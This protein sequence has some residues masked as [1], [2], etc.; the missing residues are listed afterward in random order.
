MGLWFILFTCFF[1][2]GNGRNF[3]PYKVLEISRKATASEIK[4]AYR[5]LARRFHP[6]KASNAQRA[7]F[8]QRM[9]EINEA[10]EVLTD[11]AQKVKVD[12]SLSQFVR[13]THENFKYIARKEYIWII[14]IHSHWCRD[15]P[16]ANEVMQ[17]VCAHFE[18][19]I[20]C[21]SISSDSELRLAQELGVRKVPTIL[22]RA[23]GNTYDIPFMR[24]RTDPS[25]VIK[26]VSQRFPTALKELKKLKYVQSFLQ[27]S[28]ERPKAVFV[29]Q[30][31]SNPHIMHRW[32]AHQFRDH[33]TFCFL[34]LKN[35]HSSETDQ[36][37][38]IIGE[39]LDVPMLAL[40]EG[41]DLLPTVI[42]L[43]NDPEQMF[44][45]LDST[46][47]RVPRIPELQATEYYNRCYTNME[48]SLFDSSK[49]CILLLLSKRSLWAKYQ[50]KLVPIAEDQDAIQFIW[51]DCKKQNVFCNEWTQAEGSPSTRMFQR[52]VTLRIVGV[53]G[54]Q[55]IHS[56]SPI[57]TKHPDYL[58][59]ED[60]SNWVSKFVKNEPGIVM[61]HGHCTLPQLNPGLNLGSGFDLEDGWFQTLTSF[62]S[63]TVST[64]SSAIS[65]IINFLFTIFFLLVFLLVMCVMGGRGGGFQFRYL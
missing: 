41:P 63:A 23:A 42:D 40:F 15:C 56:L 50:K 10:Y 30:T 62:G 18:G 24:H 45:R 28:Q 5:S 36:L 29:S 11:N 2:L 46:F 34:P 20:N 16:K 33:A 6:D 9:K 17:K 19:M 58:D 47:K 27:K 35:F 49:I 14:L 43:T 61:Q 31:R 32:L 22:Y 64:T 55:N 1:I 54:P 39:K 52:E 38:E 48:D 4:R 60:I 59:R 57:L 21:G 3:N 26:S 44:Y 8:E 65:Q 12:Q 25:S 7:S 51:V 53:R 37:K 13:F